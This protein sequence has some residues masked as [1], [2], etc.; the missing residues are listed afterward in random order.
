MKGNSYHFVYNFKEK[1]CYFSNIQ[2]EYIFQSKNKQILLCFNNNDNAHWSL[3]PSLK[4]LSY[5]PIS[6][7]KN[8]FN[9]SLKHSDTLMT[10]LMTLHELIQSATNLWQFFN[11][12]K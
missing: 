10:H 12:F 7:T 5:Y 4:K 6:Y 3:P 9:G 11:V 1:L 8:T 2:K